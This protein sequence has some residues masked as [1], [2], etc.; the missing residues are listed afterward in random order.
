MVQTL[1][2]GGGTEKWTGHCCRA[3]PGGK[4]GR[5]GWR[6]KP[7]PAREG[8]CTR[9]RQGGLGLGSGVNTPQTCQI[10]WKE[11]LSPGS[12]SPGYRKNAAPQ[13]AL[14]AGDRLSI[15]PATFLRP[16]SAGRG[17]GDI[18]GCT[19]L[20]VGL[21]PL[22]EVR[23]THFGLSETLILGTGSAEK[24]TQ[25]RIKNTRSR[26][27]WGKSDSALYWGGIFLIRC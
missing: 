4:G 15:V 3:R 9:S 8:P 11:N 10:V 20:A 5:R 17:S 25:H 22:H 1:G 18:Q 16:L 21:G 12:P 13:E 14:Q 26:D 7:K 6:E 23:K 24:S 19:V 27:A 2:G